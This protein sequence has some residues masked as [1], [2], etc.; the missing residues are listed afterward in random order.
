MSAAATAKLNLAL[1]VGPQRPD[2][3]HDVVTVLQRRA[4]VLHRGQP[5]QAGTVS[6]VRPWAFAAARA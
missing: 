2:G 3:K 1:V 6:Q 5:Y 4:A